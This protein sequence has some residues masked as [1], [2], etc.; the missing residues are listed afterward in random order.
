[1]VDVVS[2]LYCREAIVKLSIENDS[3]AWY[4]RVQYSRKAIRRRGRPTM[5]FDAVV[6]D[7][8]SSDVEINGYRVIWRFHPN[9]AL[10]H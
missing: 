3:T 8:S 4:S 7:E 2:V 9:A 5:T 1:M 10:D 6:H